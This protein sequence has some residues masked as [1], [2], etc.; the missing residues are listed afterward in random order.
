[1]TL[2]LVLGGTRSGKSVVAEQMAAAAVEGGVPVTYVATGVATE[3]AMAA[4]IARHKA[5]RPPAWRTIEGVAAPEL[6]TALRA[7]TGVVLLDS[8]GTWVAAHPDLDPDGPALA[9]VLAARSDDT[10]VVSEEVGL[11]V[12]PPTPVG[13]R[14]V[15]VLGDVNRAVADVADRAVLIVAGRLLELGPAAAIPPRAL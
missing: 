13:R 15:D 9:A 4:R 2:T 8:L 6:S 12:H 14:F 10:I 3:E 1:M 11:S 7:L 5:R